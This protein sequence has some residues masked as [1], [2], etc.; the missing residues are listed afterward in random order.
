MLS[1][2]EV[3]MKRV[4]LLLMVA[5]VAPAAFAASIDD[6]FTGTALSPLWAWANEDNCAG[7]VHNALVLN[8]QTGNRQAAIGTVGRGYSWV[9]AGTPMSYQFTVE[10]W[11]IVT[12]SFVSARLFLVG[13][14]A[15]RQPVAFS[16][17]DKPHVLMGKL[18][19]WQGTFYWNLFVKT[20]SPQ[21]NADADSAKLAWLEV[22]PGV[23]GYTFGVTLKGSTAH[24]WWTARDGTQKVADPATVPSALFSDGATV[25]IGM[26]ND[27][28]EPFGDDEVVRISN[29]RI[30]PEIPADR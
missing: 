18:D 14:E 3:R 9:T 2:E 16:D 10:S 5:A 19:R 28:G 20:R 24:L 21:S 25:Y 17:Y 1:G 23:D 22:G 4:L 27:T 15:D 13:N 30:G 6:R 7:Y 11:N 26:K 29:V 12:N 8:P